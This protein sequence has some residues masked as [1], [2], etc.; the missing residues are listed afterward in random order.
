[1]PRMPPI[2]PASYRRAWSGRGRTGGGRIEIKFAAAAWMRITGRG[3]VATLDRRGVAG[4]WTATMIA[5]ASGVRV[6]ID[7]RETRYAP[8]HELMNA[9]ALLVQE[10]FRRDPHS[11]N[12]YR[13]LVASG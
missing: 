9:L 2:K 6:W 4:R 12:L 8:W 5:T 13:S 11:D 10:A 1:F 7:D 3:E